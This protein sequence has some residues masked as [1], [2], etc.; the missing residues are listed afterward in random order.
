MNLARF[1][2]VKIV[3]YADVKDH[4][5]FW[6][7]EMPIIV[8]IGLVLQDME[9]VLSV[10]IPEF[11]ECGLFTLLVLEGQPSFISVDSILLWCS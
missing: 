9:V 11:E 8:T 5:V 3:V 6:Q 4:L 2:V 7:M 1:L 10:D